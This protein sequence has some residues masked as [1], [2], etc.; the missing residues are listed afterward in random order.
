M[1]GS[2]Q[3]SWHV[4]AYCEG[5]QELKPPVGRGLV[6]VL[7]RKLSYDTRDTLLQQWLPQLAKRIADP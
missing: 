1:N 7:D 6:F 3:A 4:K 5:E 2:T